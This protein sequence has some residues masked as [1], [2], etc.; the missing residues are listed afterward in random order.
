MSQPLPKHVV[1]FGALRSGTTLLRLMLDQHPRLAAPGETDYMFDYASDAPPGDPDYDMAAMSDDR[2]YR[3]FCET[4]GLTP[5]TPRT[6]A[7]MLRTMQAPKAAEDATV[8]ILLHRNLGR[9]LTHLPGVRVLHLVRDPRDVAR[10]SVG[11]GWAGS[12][13]YGVRHWIRTER[14]WAALAPRLA[15]DQVLQVKYEDLI[16]APETTLRRVCGFFGMDYDPRLLDYD[17]ESTYAKPDPALTYQ[18][19]RKQSPR[20]I[21]LV[22]ARVG[23]LLA[24]LGYEPSGHPP[25]VPGTAE[26]ILL[27]LK[28]RKA[29]WSRRF[30]RFGLRDPLLDWATRRMGVPALGRPARRRMDAAMKRY[31]K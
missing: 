29:T 26:R 1:V 22:E 10:S 21:G 14:E 18:W 30:R 13:Y 9:A 31:V 2:I 27:A 28:Q 3:V 19:R 24:S 7:G 23:E 20:E 11:M 4:F 12:T 5:E 15:P 16:E 8:V 6:M 17:G 25:V